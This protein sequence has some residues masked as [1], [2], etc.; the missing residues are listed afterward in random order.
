VVYTVHLPAAGSY[1]IDVR[2]AAAAAGA[3]VRVGFGGGEVTGDVALAATGGG[4]RTATVAGGVA[5]R[6]GV[7]AL[8]VSIAGAA[9]GFALDSITVSGG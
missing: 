7:Q 9:D 8:R 2:Y 6:A 5:L 3:S 4:W 1:R